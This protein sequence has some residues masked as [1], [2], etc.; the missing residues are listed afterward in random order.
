[1]C[2]MTIFFETFPGRARGGR[3]GWVYTLDLQSHGHMTTDLAFPASLGEEGEEGGIAAS[4]SVENLSSS[5]SFICFS[6]ISDYMLD[7]FP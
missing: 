5:N 7:S 6:H 2:G 1:M 4:F 3:K